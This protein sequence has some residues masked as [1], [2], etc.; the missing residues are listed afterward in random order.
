M[1]TFLLPL[2]AAI[3]AQTPGKA[4]EAWP[5]GPTPIGLR[6]TAD[7]PVQRYI[8]WIVAVENALPSRTPKEIIRRIRRMHYSNFSVKLKSKTSQ[9]MDELIGS[10]ADNPDDEPPLTT[11][12]VA[13]PILDGLFSTSGVVTA[14]GHSVDITHALN[15]I[16]FAVNGRS[17]YAAP[18]ELGTWLAP[19]Y[20][21]ANPELVFASL[22]WLGDLASVWFEWME[23]RPS[24]TQATAL[25]A[26]R[27]IFEQALTDR[28]PVGDLLGDIDGAVLATLPELSHQPLS[29]T[30]GTYY[31]GEASTAA[32]TAPRMNSRQR[33]HYFV[34][35]SIPEFVYRTLPV[36]QLRVAIAASN[37]AMIADVF[38]RLADITWSHYSRI[39]ERDPATHDPVF[40]E[41]ANRFLKWVQDALADPNLGVPPWPPAPTARPT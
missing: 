37:A 20:E 3:V 26:E 22:G 27:A 11:A 15:I 5:N 19:N 2:I 23:K 10:T 12:H 21:T 18:A 6:A 34:D 40:L 35:R 29:V 41:L 32:M 4:Q 24:N 36:A 39:A 8:D 17:V 13:Q 33:F 25:S 14:A 7:V 1:N 9:T 28:C 38:K 16:D 31:G 30:L